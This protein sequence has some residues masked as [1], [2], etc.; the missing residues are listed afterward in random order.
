ME[1]EAVREARQQ[2]ERGAAALAEGRVS[3]ALNAYNQAI[4]LAPDYLAGRLGRAAALTM[5]GKFVEAQ[6]ELDGIL[7]RDPDSAE[8]FAAWG[9]L[10]ALQGRIGAAEEKYAR[11]FEL[12][13]DQPSQVTGE[14]AVL[15]SLLRRNQEA[16]DLFEKAKASDPP[17]GPNALVHWGASLDRLGRTAEAVDK[18]QAALAQVPEEPTILNNLGFLLFRKEIDRERGLELMQRA[19]AS[20]P[21][22]PL[23]LHNLG[24]ALLQ[25]DRP[26]E[27][28]SLLRRAAAAT[29]ASEKA[30]ALRQQHLREAREKLP[31]SPATPEMQIVILLFV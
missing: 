31:S 15:L 8:A 26:E 14:R 27:A 5:A 28:Y 11:A 21:G 23:L 17:L 2:V 10:L 9:K 12:D 19:V 13:D 29:D 20:R 25:V 22:D 3:D 7:Q 18:Y 6:S 4:V 24:W 30:Y 16:V 1:S